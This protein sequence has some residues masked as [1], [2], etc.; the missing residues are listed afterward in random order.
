VSRV[1]L[2][3]FKVLKDFKALKVFQFK[4]LRVLLKVLKDFKALKEDRELKVLQVLL[5][6]LKVCREHRD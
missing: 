3:L 6:V 2:V 1:L 5:K 4:V